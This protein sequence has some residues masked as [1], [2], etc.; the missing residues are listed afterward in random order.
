MSW[1]RSGIR[2]TTKLSIEESQSRLEAEGV[3][4]WK[5]KSLLSRRE[6][7]ELGFLWSKKVGLLST[8]LQ[9]PALIGTLVDCEQGCQVHVDFRPNVSLRL[10][11]LSITPAAAFFFIGVA[12]PG[13]VTPVSSVLFIAALIFVGFLL[14]M[15]SLFMRPHWKQLVAHL[16]QIIPVDE[17]V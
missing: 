1:F 15:I 2:F 13:R 10:L 16:Q 12:I 11:I 6:T 8:L 5:V 4:V 9:G 14:G 17:V 3:S 7:G